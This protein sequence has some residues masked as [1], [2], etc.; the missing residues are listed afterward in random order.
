MLLLAKR[1]PTPD[2]VAQLQERAADGERLAG[3]V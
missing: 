3:R 1:P 2:A